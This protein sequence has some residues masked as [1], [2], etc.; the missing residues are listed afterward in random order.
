M[1]KWAINFK[2]KPDPS[3]QKLSW[4]QQ[5]FRTTFQIYKP[6]F[7]PQE[8]TIKKYSIFVWQIPGESLMCMLAVLLHEPYREVKHYNNSNTK[9]VNDLKSLVISSGLM[10]SRF[11]G[12]L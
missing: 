4:R 9:A 12:N 1:S 2:N 3:T 7:I 8:V 11:W 6:S 5:P 10:L